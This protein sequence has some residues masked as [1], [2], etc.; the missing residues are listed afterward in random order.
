MNLFFI[1]IL[2][3]LCCVKCPSGMDAWPIPVRGKH[4]K[5]CT[6]VFWKQKVKSHLL[7]MGFTALGTKQIN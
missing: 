5:W 6:S 7:L 2:T 4:F 1:K 3:V